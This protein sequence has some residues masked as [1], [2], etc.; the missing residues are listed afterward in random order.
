MEHLPGGHTDRILMQPFGP[1]K[2]DPHRVRC[3]N[4]AGAPDFTRYGHAVTGTG[5]GTLS[6]H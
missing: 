5:T 4:P 1:G 3:T 2:H 6:L